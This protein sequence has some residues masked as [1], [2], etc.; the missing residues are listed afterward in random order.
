MRPPMQLANATY[1][2]IA[3][4][5][6]S[7]RYLGTAQV[8]WSPRPFRVRHANDAEGNPILLCRSSG[9][10]ARALAQRENGSGINRHP[11]HGNG[12]VAVVLA[13]DFSVGRVWVSGWAHPICGD[14]TRAAAIEFA[15]TNPVSDLLALGN[16]FELHH[17]DVVEVRLETNTCE[18]MQSD[19]GHRSCR[20]RMV[21]IDVAAY[22]A[23]SPIAEGEGSSPVR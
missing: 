17:L 13:V 11:S 4:T 15:T 14:A 9:G 8:A 22:A 20:R 6:A 16:G 2:E 19:P 7:G 18:H 23:A 1:A 5:V 12:D 3:R 21:D 10:L